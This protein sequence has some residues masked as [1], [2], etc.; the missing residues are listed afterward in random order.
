VSPS[1]ATILDNH[2]INFSDEALLQ[3]SQV[4]ALPEPESYNMKNFRMWLRDPNAGHFS[5]GGSGEQNTWGDLYKVEENPG[6]L[7]WQFVKLLWNLI[8][9]RSPPSNDLDLAATRRPQNIDGF[10][11]WVASDFIPFYTNLRRYREKRKRRAAPDEE[12]VS[13]NPSIS[14]RPSK[15]TLKKEFQKETLAT[16]SE[17][18]MLKFTSAVSTVVAC[19]LP[20]VAIVVLSQVQ[21]MRNLLLCLA[22]FTVIFSVGLI[23]LTSGTTTRVEIFTAT[24]A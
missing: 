15:S 1:G 9:P 3:Y 10:T 21:G 7:K 22:G 18:S 13:V 5:I 8:W 19:L 14:T 11:R 4:S 23:F 16:Y 6:S 20:T 2:L 12:R 24:A 17:R